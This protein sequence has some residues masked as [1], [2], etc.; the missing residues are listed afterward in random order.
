MGHFENPH[1]SSASE[2]PWK[3]FHT[4]E[5]IRAG[6]IDLIQGVA[7]YQYENKAHLITTIERILQEEGYPGDASVSVAK[8]EERP[9]QWKISIEASSPIDGTEVECVSTQPIAFNVV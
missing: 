2:N 8:D 1:F 7:G 9:G 4:N 3:K 5:E 6:F